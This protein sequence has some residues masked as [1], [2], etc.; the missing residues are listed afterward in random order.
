[1]ATSGITSTGI[2]TGLDITTLVGKLVDAEGQPIFNQ[3]AKKEDTTND[4]L[5]ALGSLKSALTSLQTAAKAL[6]DAD[7]FLLHSATSGNDS[8]VTA[9]ATSK[10]VP[11]NY[12]V[13]VDHLA[14]SQQLVANATF[15]SGAA[16]V[17]TGSLT[18]QVGSE[19]ANSF[20]VTIGTNNKS[21]ASIRDAINSAAD[22]KGVQASIMNVDDGAGGTVSRLL[23]TSKNTGLSN[24]VTVTAQDDDGNNTDNSGLSQLASSNLTEKTPAQNALIK[25]NG[26]DVT[27]STNTISDAIDG[28]T[29]NLIAGAPGTTVNVGVAT[30]NAAISKNI[31]DFVKAYNSL[32]SVMKNLGSYNATTKQAG[33]LL[34]DA[35]LNGLKSQVRSALSQQ[36]SGTAAAFSTL[37]MLGVEIDGYGTMTLNQSK[38]DTAL[39]TDPTSVSAVFTSATGVAQTLNDRIDTYLQTG[40]IFDTR[41]Q[42]LNATLRTITDDRARQ[43]D[44]MEALQTRLLKQFNTM[45]SMVAKINS[46]GTYLSQQLTALS[47]STSK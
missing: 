36:V 20:T 29:L 32:G 44:R 30:D 1:M 7:K 19:V 3:L 41:T 35:M 16:D 39:A 23:L 10:A 43:Q 15:T 9:T 22:N 4:R 40:G 37:Q 8:I 34:G 38:L 13:I 31:S 5:S 11:G 2:G 17:G 18:L 25:L 46:V 21:L 33:I 45:D 12:A 6:K 47:K 24:T 42:Q 28:I 26:Y 14:T 27:R